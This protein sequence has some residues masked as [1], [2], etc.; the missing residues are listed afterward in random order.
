M[1]SLQEIREKV[2]FIQWKSFWASGSESH[3][4]IS[5]LKV[6][7]ALHVKNFKMFTHRGKAPKL[8]T[9]LAWNDP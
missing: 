7:S 2:T 6:S 9:S 4:I 3:P 5:T 8:K 1:V